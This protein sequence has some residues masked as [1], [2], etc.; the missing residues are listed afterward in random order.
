M[1]RLATLSNDA[2]TE[3]VATAVITGGLPI[4]T[5]VSDWTLPKSVGLLSMSILLPLANTLS[6]ES[7]KLFPVKQEK[8]NL[9]R[10]IVQ[11]KLETICDAISHAMQDRSISLAEFYKVTQDLEKYRKRKAD[12]RNQTINQCKTDHKRKARIIARTRK[13]KKQG[14]FFMVC[15]FIIYKDH[16]TFYSQIV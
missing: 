15:D 1:Q 10:L 4:L 5:F 6:R 14:R 16:K 3:L 9:I 12:T 13:K 7:S 2:G 8:H 11:T